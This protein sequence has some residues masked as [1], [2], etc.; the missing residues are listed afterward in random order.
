MVPKQR[1]QPVGSRSALIEFLD[2]PRHRSVELPSEVLRVGERFEQDFLFVDQ[3]SLK[4]DY[5]LEPFSGI[6]QGVRIHRLEVHLDVGAAT[7]LV[8][9][10]R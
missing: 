6:L 10:K 3:I 5:L 4:G 1:M 2:V 7:G 9:V 8:S